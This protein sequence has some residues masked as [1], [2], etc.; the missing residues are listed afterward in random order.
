MMRMID[1]H[2]M[3]CYLASSVE[4][5]SDHPELTAFA[6][7]FVTREQAEADMLKGWL[8]DWFNIDY[9]PHTEPGFAMTLYLFKIRTLPE[10]NTEFLEH[11]VIYETKEMF[12]ARQIGRLA[13]H[14]DLKNLALDILDINAGEL[15]QL[16]TWMTSWGVA[17]GLPP[18]AAGH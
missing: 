16:N 6:R 3:A 13:V 1:D 2:L 10:F 4:V 18:A 7:S 5:K 9:R 14:A 11:L 17:T 15:N 8:H 12:Q